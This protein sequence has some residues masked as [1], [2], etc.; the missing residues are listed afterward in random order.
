M[1]IFL[2]VVVDKGQKG[3]DEK[4]SSKRSKLVLLYYSP[5]RTSLL[6]SRRTCR[7]DLAL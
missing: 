7:S 3:G 1:L 2:V 5:A 6:P 4:F